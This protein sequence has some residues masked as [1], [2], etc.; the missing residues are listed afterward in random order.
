MLGQRAG[1]VGQ[2][3]LERFQIVAMHDKIVVQAHLG[4]EAL[5]LHQLQLVIRHEQMKILVERFA[6]EI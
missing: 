2:Q 4:R 1:V 5:G 6:L 3:G